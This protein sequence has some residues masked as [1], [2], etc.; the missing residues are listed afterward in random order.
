M[1]NRSSEE[2]GPN[3]ISRRTVL[4]GATSAALLAASPVALAK[5]A[6]KTERRGVAGDAITSPMRRYMAAAVVLQD[7][8]V[9]ITG[10]YDRPWN[11]RDRI[12]PLRSAMIYDPNADEWT[13]AGSMLVGRARHAAVTLEDGRVAVIG[14]IA[15]RPTATVELFDPRTARWAMGEPLE[16]PRYDHTAAADGNAVYVLGGSAQSMLGGAELLRFPA[17]RPFEEE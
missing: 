13:S 3:Q 7:G 6:R 14:G 16:Q 1:A 12:C 10:G 4:L 17:A 15:M 11:G 9:L 8:R 2:P 5:S